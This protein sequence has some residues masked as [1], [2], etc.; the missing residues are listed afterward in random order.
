MMDSMCQI[1]R[2]SVEPDRFSRACAMGHSDP[3]LAL[4]PV[5]GDPVADALRERQSAKLAPFEIGRMQTP[6]DSLGATSILARRRTAAC[7]FL[8]WYTEMFFRNALQGL[9]R[10][11]NAA[12]Q[13]TKDH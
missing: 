11:Y 2:W 12:S 13:F 8:V 6:K 9:E 4:R 7:P 5:V 10:Q 3:I 1:L